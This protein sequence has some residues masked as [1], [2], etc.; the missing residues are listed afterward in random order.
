MPTQPRLLAT[1]YDVHG[2]LL[3]EFWHY[4]AEQVLY[5]R[6]FGNLT[7][8]EVIR[9]AKQ[10]AEL[11]SWLHSPLIL[12]DK[13]HASGDWSEAITWLEYEW[14]PQALDDGLHALAYVF[15]SD[16]SNQIVS[17][18]FA[19]RLKPYLPVRLFYDVPKAWSWLRRQSLPEQRV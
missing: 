18:E 6:W 3:A 7:A 12:N 10:A 8:P 1:V 17:L 11:Q 16:V 19:K 5:A 13:H 9:G 14:L 4:Q 15:A 2:Q